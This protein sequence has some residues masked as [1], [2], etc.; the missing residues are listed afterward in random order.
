MKSL[1]IPFLI[2]LC[3][4]PSWAVAQD[5]SP[6]LSSD[7]KNWYIVGLNIRTSPKNTVSFS[8]LSSFDVQNYQ[9]GFMQN[10]VALSRNLGKRWTGQLGYAHSTIM[11]TT[12]PNTTYHRIHLRAQH[13]VKLGRF[14]MQ[15]RLQVEKYFP[16]L[17]K[18]GARAV[19]SNKWSYYNRDLPLRISPYIRNQVF[20]YQGGS[21]ITYWLPAT[22]IEDGGPNS[23]SQAPN[24]WHRYRLSIGARMRLQRNLYLSIFYTLQREFNTGL[25]PYRE[26]NVPNKSGTRIKRPFNSYSL[27]GVSLNYTIK[28]Y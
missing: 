21:P 2:L 5:L 27:V 25:A 28:T 11:R 6:D 19:F 15:N 24:G 10:Q 8:H 3:L 23:I 4:L 14:R 7:F 20:Y 13:Q 18:F 17:Q 22:D 9:H 26:L 16:S 12:R 1:V